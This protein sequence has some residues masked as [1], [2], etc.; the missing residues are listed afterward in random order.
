MCVNRVADSTLLI[1]RSNLHWKSNSHKDS[2]IHLHHAG[3]A[4]AVASTV[5][6]AAP[7]GKGAAGTSKGSSEIPTTG[8]TSARG[9]ATSAG[10]IAREEE[11]RRQAEAREERLTNPLPEQRRQTE[12]G[13]EEQLWQAE[14]QEEKLYHALTKGA[15]S[16]RLI[17]LL[18]F[19]LEPW[20][21][22]KV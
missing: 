11:L 2:A 6:G 10:G 7:T 13:E 20:M 9:R 3:A 22:E 21:R 12:A 5:G 1:R 8:A 17:A 14:A 4:E 16:M 19:Y 15:T 18:I